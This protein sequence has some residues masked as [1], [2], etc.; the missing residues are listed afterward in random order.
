M[1]EMESQGKFLLGFLIQVV[2]KAFFTPKGYVY[3]STATVQ[4]LLYV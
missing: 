3:L 2:E 4:E 1:V